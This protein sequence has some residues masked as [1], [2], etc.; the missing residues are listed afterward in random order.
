MDNTLSRAPLIIQGNFKPTQL[1]RW[2]KRGERLVTLGLLLLT[3][4]CLGFYSAIIWRE[5]Q[6]INLSEE[7]RQTTEANTQLEAN[8]HEIQSFQA[9]GKRLEQVP[10]LSE[11]KNRLLIELST[12]NANHM[13]LASPDEHWETWLP[14]SKKQHL[15]KQLTGL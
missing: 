5:T 10:G 1:E 13:L 8:L 4:I 15:P 7:A 3:L 6:L 14:V 12:T 2:L 9:L 11:A